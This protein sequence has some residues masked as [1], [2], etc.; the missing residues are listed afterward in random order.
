MIKAIIFDRDG[1][2]I[3]S[4]PINTSSV[5]KTLKELGKTLSQKDREVIIGKHPIDYIKSFEKT[6]SLCGNDFIDKL[7]KHYKKLILSAKFF[8]S[9]IDL[10]KQLKNTKYLLG[11][12]TSSGVECTKT[13]LGRAKLDNHF[14]TIVTLEECKKR[15]PDPEPYLITAK[16]LGVKSKEC[17][18]IEDSFIGLEAAKSAGMKCIVIPNNSTKHQNFSKADHIASN[19]DEIKTILRK[20]S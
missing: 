13:I 5:I 10:I 7:D 1:V 14:D 4:E 12:T 19:A 16:K 8:D 6:Y 20:L 18:V 11:L 15:K 3:D 9:T 17:I 2:I